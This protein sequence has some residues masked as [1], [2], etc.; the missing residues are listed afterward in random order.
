MV[1]LNELPM[2][3][4]GIVVAAGVGFLLWTLYHLTWEAH[5]NSRRGSR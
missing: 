3:A 1:S 4:L 2:V 5:P